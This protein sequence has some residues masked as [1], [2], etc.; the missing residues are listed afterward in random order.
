MQ[1]VTAIK[2]DGPGPQSLWLT[3]GMGTHDEGCATR[4][5]PAREGAADGMLQSCQVDL[6][7][8]VLAG[9]GTAWVGEETFPF[10]RHSLAVLPAG[11][12]HLLLPE[13]G[14]RLATLDAAARAAFRQAGSQAGSPSGRADP[15]GR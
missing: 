7:V 2:L 5:S 14:G 6:L 15:K 10:G 11:T 9:N 12:P 3:G 8:F 1:H 13:R 4:Y